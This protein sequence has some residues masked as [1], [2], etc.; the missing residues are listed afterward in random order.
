MQKSVA[1]VAALGL[2]A[3][4]TMEAPRAAPADAFFTS[5]SAYCGQAFEGRIVSTD[6]ADDDWRGQ[7][8][9]MHV[10]ECS[11]G[12]IRIPLHVGEDRSRT[13]IVTRT[14]TGL[15]L[16]HDH[17]HEDGSDD[18]VTMYGGD[19]RTPGLAWRQEFPVDDYSIEMFE[20]EGLPASV[21]N[22]WALELRDDE[23]AYELRR[24]PIPG[25]RHFRAEFDLTDPVTPPP[26]P[27]GSE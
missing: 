3:C 8:M 26:P 13:W 22:I 27:W 24:P 2:G 5:L 7:R 17:R 14:G 16:K 12:Q 23:F 11:D 6:E 1:I 19:T 15:R 4:A 21:T 20:R 10:S 25:G 18:A 9:V